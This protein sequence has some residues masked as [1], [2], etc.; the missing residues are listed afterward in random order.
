MN[1]EIYNDNT[2]NVIGLIRM[3]GSFDAQVSDQEA[4]DCAREVLFDYAEPQTPGTCKAQKHWD[5]SRSRDR[6]STMHS[7]GKPSVSSSSSSSSSLKVSI[8]EKLIHKSCTRGNLDD[9][10]I[11]IVPLQGFVTASS[12]VSIAFFFSRSFLH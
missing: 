9:I 7:K 12:Q 5:S 1:K 3:R 8:C 10:T 6:D 4:V 11:L 2:C